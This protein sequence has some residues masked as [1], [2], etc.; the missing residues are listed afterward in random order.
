MIGGKTGTAETLPRDNNEYVVS[1]MG[2]APADD[3]Q[4]V[5]YVVVDRPN[6]VFRMTRNTPPK[7]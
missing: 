7:L 2:Y 5:I 1:F 6:V 3:P 4:V